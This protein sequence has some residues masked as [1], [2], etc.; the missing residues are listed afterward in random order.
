M[1]STVYILFF[2]DCPYFYIGSTTNFSKRLSSHLYELKSGRHVNINFQ[3]TWNNVSKAKLIRYTTIDFE[4]YEKANAFELELI[5]ASL[6]NPYMLNIGLSPRAGDLLSNNPNKTGI[7]AKRSITRL[8]NWYKLSVEER[9]QIRDMRGEKNPM[10]GRAHSEEAKRM[11]SEKHK[12]HKR[13][14]GIKLSAEH[15]RKISERQKKRIGSLNSFYGRKHSETTK[16]FL[17]ERFKGQKPTNCNKIAIGD[18]VYQTQADAARALG[19]SIALI[20]YRLKNKE[21][22][23]EYR[24]L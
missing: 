24:R 2:T 8:D 1:Q 10:H 9:R 15:I 5:K 4:N 21:K 14:V 6:E 13:N 3:N 22:Y 20:T 16:K 12:G 23:P 17:S 18:T 19:V 11:M 7:I